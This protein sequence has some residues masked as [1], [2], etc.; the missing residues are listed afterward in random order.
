MPDSWR[1]AEEHPETGEL[2]IGIRLRKEK[3]R[4][5][6]WSSPRLYRWDGQEFV[7]FALY[8]SESESGED[9]ILRNPEPTRWMPV[10]EAPPIPDT[11][12]SRDAEARGR[13][14]HAIRLK[15]LRLE[16]QLRED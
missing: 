5:W 8:T 3:Y 13:K 6:S 7:G 4:Q 16:R 1:S 11:P 2:V 9:E 12:E 10:P 15:I 14:Y